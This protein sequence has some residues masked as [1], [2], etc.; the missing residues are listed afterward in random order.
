MED[1]DEASWRG[2][3]A[4]QL[5]ALYEAALLDPLDAAPAALLDQVQATMAALEDYQARAELVRPSPLPLP[6]YRL[7][8][9]RVAD[10][11]AG[12]VR[13]SPP[14]RP[15]AEPEA[16]RL[17]RS[18]VESDAVADELRRRA[19]RLHA[20]FALVDALEAYV[21]RVDAAVGQ[22]EGQVAAAERALHAAEPSAA[23]ALAANVSRVLDVFKW[24]RAAPPPPPPPRPLLPPF[25]PVVVPPR[26]DVAGIRR[27][28]AAAWARDKD[29][30]H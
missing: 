8:L 18:A 19:E 21:D 15:P 9:T 5:C 12:Q 24:A 3:L 14:S 23:A 13:A 28:A 25:E 29:A 26:A 7:S 17:P 20:A 4:L 1:G 2:A 11:C 6:P 16:Y 22:L 27:D 10:R 30:V